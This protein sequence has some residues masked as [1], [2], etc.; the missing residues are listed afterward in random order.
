MSA[1]LKCNGEVIGTPSKLQIEMAQRILS[2]W[3]LAE[4]WLVFWKVRG[5]GTGKQAHHDPDRNWEF[6]VCGV[7]LHETTRVIDW[8]DSEGILADAMRRD[9]QFM[10]C[11]KCAG[12][13]QRR[14]RQ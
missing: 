10:I 5:E 6:A 14:R 11:E 12:E 4:Q 1:Q 9:L 8:L 3:T 2:D 13:K 7:A